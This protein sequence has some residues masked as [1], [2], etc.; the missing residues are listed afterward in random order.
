[1]N[2]IHLLSWLRTALVAF[3]LTNVFGSAAFGQ[4][5]WSTKAPMPAPRAD[6]SVGVLNGT[7]YAV[8]GNHDN[9]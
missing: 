7:L 1:M 4:N 9:T 8:G 5:T 3:A 6:V 2:R